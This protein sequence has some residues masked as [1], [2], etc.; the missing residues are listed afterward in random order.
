MIVQSLWLLVELAALFLGVAFFIQLFQRRFGAARLRRWMG[1]PP[2]AAA[3]KGIA[4]GFVT[5][6]CTYSAIPMLV[7]LRQAGVPPA[8]YVAFIAA[9]PVLDPV[10][11]GALVIIVGPEAALVYTALTFTAA[12]TLALVAQRVGI[13]RHLK[14]LPAVANGV[15]TSPS[16]VTLGAS[17]SMPLSV[18]GSTGVPMST[19]A[20]PSPSNADPHAER[21]GDGSTDSAAVAP[22]PE[23]GGTCGVGGS[24]QPWQGLGP[25]SR[26]AMTAAVQLLRSVGL[27]LLAGV[28]VGL[29][30]EAVVSPEAI[31]TIT[32]SNA[33]WSIPLAAML[34]TPLYV[35]TSL[36]VPVADALAGAGVGIGAIVALT[37]S[38]AGANV[39]EFI[40]LTKLA[41]RRLIA[42]FFGYVFCVAL[43]GGLIAQALLG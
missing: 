20:L 37:V 25:E 23:A 29:L 33:A 17:E 5:P 15:V 21:V 24:D 40:I 12:L 3:L 36:F 38:G 10:L 42:T 7:G 41:A 31:A 43:V 19:A 26:R 27:L 9:A 34:G 35:Q 39:P 4:V 22:E 18:T 2:L 1:G 16:A 28:G 32:G 30:I 11:F 8:G 13:E 6:F 14:P